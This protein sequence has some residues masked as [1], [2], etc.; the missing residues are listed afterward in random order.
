MFTLLF[1]TFIMLY[2]SLFP[3]STEK[4]LKKMTPTSVTSGICRHATIVKFFS[5]RLYLVN[6]TIMAPL[7][8]SM[9][10]SVPVGKG[11]NIQRRDVE[12]V[13]ATW[14][15]ILL[16]MLL[17][18]ATH[19]VTVINLPG[20]AASVSAAR[21]LSALLLPFSGVVKGFRAICVAKKYGEDDLKH[22]ARVGALCVVARSTNWEP[23]EGEGPS[24]WEPHEGE[25]DIVFRNRK[26]QYVRSSKRIH[27]RCILPEG[28]YLRQLPTNIEVS[29][30]T[31]DGEPEMGHQDSIASSWN[32]AA[33][34]IA[35]VQIGFAISTLWRARGSQLE[36]YGYAAFSLTVIPYAIMS[37]INLLGN[38]ATPSYEYLYILRSTVLEEAQKRPGAVID[39]TVGMVLPPPL[40]QDEAVGSN[41]I[42]HGMYNRQYLPEMVGR[43]ELAQEIGPYRLRNQSSYEKRATRFA[44][45]LVF[46]ALV[47]PYALIGGL[48]K[49]QSQQST[50]AQR[51]W[52]MSWLVVG[53]FYGA[54][55]PIYEGFGLIP[56]KT[57]V[58][59]WVEIVAMLPVLG[60]AGIGGLITVGMM[61][62]DYGSYC[63][64]V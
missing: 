9:V 13:A 37:A 52:T 10:E 3:R 54:A 60:V 55:L 30:A 50:K 36:R 20:D 42:Y 40:N 19:V 45:V 61:I 14:Q 24:N 28:Y 48:T 44:G 58:K 63:V 31:P 17:N 53:Q 64:T 29:W 2:S 12:C 15:R 8:L 47:A 46:I 4:L 34:V 21:K 39:G 51:G 23:H 57:A 59:A 7:F 62:R 11:T 35:L 22:A 1:F 6:L 25:A 38:I 26:E 49:F 18:Y 56:V 32:I 41:D 16:F 33:G 27:G 5:L 43:D